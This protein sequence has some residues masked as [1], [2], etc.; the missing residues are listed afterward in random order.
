MIQYTPRTSMLAVSIV[1][2]LFG[3]S[4]Q[5]SFAQ[6]S[7]SGPPQDCPQAHI[8]ATAGTAAAN[9][10]DD[11]NVI[12]TFRMGNNFAQDLARELPDTTSWQNPYPASA[13]SFGTF[14]D[15]ANPSHISYG[16]SKE[17]GVK[18]ATEHIEELVARCPDTHFVLVGYSQGAH[19]TGDV[20]A[21]APVPPER[22]LGVYLVADPARSA[23]RDEQAWTNTG[24]VGRLTEAGAVYI[25]SNFPTPNTDMVGAAGPRE[26][27]AFAHLSG[28][29][30]QICASPDPVCATPAEG[31]FAHIIHWAESPEYAVEGAETIAPLSPTLDDGTLLR[32]F[33]PELPAFAK[34][35]HEQDPVAAEAVFQRSAAAPGLTA[36][37]R[38][39]VEFTGKEVSSLLRYMN[40]EQV[41][42]IGRVVLPLDDPVALFY[43]LTTITQST[44]QIT[45]LLRLIDLPD[46]HFSYNGGNRNFIVI[47]GARV[48]DWVAADVFNLIAEDLGVV[49][50]RQPRLA[51][52]RKTPQHEFGYLLWKLSCEI[53]GEF[54]PQTEH[55]R[56]YFD[57]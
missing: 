7:K 57:L 39:S 35:V 14:L 25:A 10:N 20:A 56:R 15:T 24:T 38:T 45:E 51:E 40:E 3:L 47:D 17:N 12:H 1:L 9:P 50:R 28:K 36:E 29:V 41:W 42:D 52:T 4:A 6:E 21:Y 32:I 5:P 31:F 30:R 23:L 27:G 34:A 33:T 26:A 43:T 18:Q 46:Y 19:V 13:G 11:P 53:H 22:I 16:A 48:D 55:L 54:S 49:E 8:V 2:G 37:Q 44:N